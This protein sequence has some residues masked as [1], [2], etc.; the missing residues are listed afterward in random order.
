MGTK[1][2]EEADTSIFTVKECRKYYSQLYR[3]KKIQN[4]GLG[5]NKYDSVVLN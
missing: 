3:G 2:S 1:V 5:Q 4:M